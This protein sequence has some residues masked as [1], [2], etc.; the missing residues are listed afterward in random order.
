MTIR[1]YIDWSGDP[2]FKFRQGSSEL[3]VV[4]ALMSDEELRMN[5]LRMQLSLPEDFEFHYSKADK[6]IREQFKNHVNSNL[7][8]PGVVILRVDKRRLPLEIRQKQGE[9][10]MAGFI[11]L[12]VANLPSGLLHNAILFYDGEKEQKSFKNTLRTAL[13]EAMHPG[14]FLRNIKAI[15]AHRIDG[16]QV[17]DMLA[18]FIRNDPASIRSSMV[19]VIQYPD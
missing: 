10:I 19:K 2:G 12:C 13:S 7:E 18:G 17:A 9:Q 3:F 8:I 4:A 16:L 15:P 5:D 1:I 6:T 14:I 11:A